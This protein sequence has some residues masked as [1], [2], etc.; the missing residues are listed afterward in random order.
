MSKRSRDD[1][2]YT[3]QGKVVKTPAVTVTGITL[4]SAN[5]TSDPY[6][7]LDSAGND[8]RKDN[9]SSDLSIQFRNEIVLD[10]ENFN[11]EIALDSPT[12]VP[13]AD[14]NVVASRDTSTFYYTWEDPAGT[15][16]SHEIVIPDG[17]RGVDEIQA[18]I[19][20]G[21]A[22]L[23]QVDA[24]PPIGY[25][26]EFTNDDSSSRITVRTN[27]QA[28]IVLTPKYNG[29]ATGIMGLFGYVGY[30]DGE[31]LAEEVYGGGV[32]GGGAASVSTYTPIKV[33]NI[34]DGVTGYYINCDV[35]KAT[36]DANGESSAIKQYL[37]S[38]SFGSQQDFTNTGPLRW[39]RVDKFLTRI[40]KIRV[41]VTD[42]KHRD[43]DWHGEASTFIL[44]LREKKLT[45]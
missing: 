25:A 43:V 15:F 10:W 39:C 8:Y 19:H 12:S 45:F 3:A 4:D 23:G 18:Y 7:P 32:L 34:S 21:M 35:T 33:A 44:L 6:N 2:I 1:E 11:Y 9:T 36:I 31:P 40:G 30:A 42:N 37:I 41:W 27:A 20:N 26:I 22:E 17:Y 14:H 16:T 5:L 38:E 28:R 29:Y 24:G 13:I